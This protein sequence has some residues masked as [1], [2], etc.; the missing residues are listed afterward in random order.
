MPTLELTIE[1]EFCGPISMGTVAVVHAL[2]LHSGLPLEAAIALVDRCTF[3]GE[4][5]A[6]PVPNRAAAQALLLALQ[7]VPA[8]PRITASISD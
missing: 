3:E 7:R 4:R 6:V 1:A 2:M 8:A 5:V